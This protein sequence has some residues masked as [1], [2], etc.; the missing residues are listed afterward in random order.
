MQFPCVDSTCAPPDCIV[1]LGL[2][3]GPWQCERLFPVALLAVVSGG[4]ILMVR[5]P[6]SAMTVSA[7]QG[8][9]G[10]ASE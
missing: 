4:L 10:A 9:N 8:S 5:S 2:N 3:R 6:D 1:L 7:E